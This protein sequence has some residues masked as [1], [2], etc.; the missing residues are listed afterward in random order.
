[1]VQIWCGINVTYSERHT[2]YSELHHVSALH[3]HLLTSHKRVT[4]INAKYSCTSVTDKR[5]ASAVL[6][7][8]QQH[9]RQTQDIC[10]QQR[11]KLSLYSVGNCAFLR[12]TSFDAFS[13]LSFLLQLRPWGRRRCTNHTQKWM[14]WCLCAVASIPRYVSILEI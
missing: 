10:R 14:R 5:L 6:I 12:G 11:Q 1:M 13:F 7:I 3:E 8:L 9:R 4:N 2:P